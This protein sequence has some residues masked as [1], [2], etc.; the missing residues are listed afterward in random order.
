MP[1]RGLQG[2]QGHSMAESNQTG[3]SLGRAG[4]TTSRETLKEKLP[5]RQPQLPRPVVTL[6]GHQPSAAARVTQ[7]LCLPGPPAEGRRDSPEKRNKEALVG[8]LCGKLLSAT[9][10]SLRCA[11]C[12][13]ASIVMM[14]TLSP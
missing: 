4:R 13:G 8:A 3:R 7:D 5:S 11:V 12:L 1:L 6:C 2:R 14:G 9:S 10:F